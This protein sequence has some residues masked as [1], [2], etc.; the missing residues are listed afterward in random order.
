M[1]A[2]HS[3]HPMAC[4]PWQHPMAC[5]PQEHPTACTPWKHSMACTSW[6]H[7]TAC[8]SW[9]APYGL[10]PTAYTPWQHPTAC[11]PLPVSHGLNP[12]ACT[13]QQHPMACTPQEAGG[14]RCSH[15][16]ARDSPGRFACAVP[17]EGAPSGLLLAKGSGGSCGPHADVRSPR[18]DHCPSQ[19]EW[20][21]P[22]G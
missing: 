19:T 5:T 1:A 12:T 21:H 17:W 13:P 7:P 14:C 4:T 15:P 16:D 18:E 2:P 9:P 20:A 22:V 3:L 6:Q 8:T 10:Y 11:T